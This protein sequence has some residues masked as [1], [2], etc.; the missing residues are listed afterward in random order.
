MEDWWASCFLPPLLVVSLR[1]LLCFFE[2]KQRNESFF[3]F[4]PRFCVSPGAFRLCPP[5]SPSVFFPFLG[6]FPP[7]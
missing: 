2:K 6:S 5:F 7:F 4:F 1:G 3:L